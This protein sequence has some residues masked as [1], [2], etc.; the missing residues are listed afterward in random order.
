MIYFLHFWSHG[1]PVDVIGDATPERYANAIRIVLDDPNVDAVL[2]IF[3]PQ[4]I[5]D[6]TETAIKVC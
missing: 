6:P 4:A 1:N 5:T 3:V 2:A